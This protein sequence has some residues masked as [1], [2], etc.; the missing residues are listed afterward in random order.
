MGRVEV[1]ISDY[2]GDTKSALDN[3]VRV[4]QAIADLAADAGWLDTAL[5]TMHLI[6]GLMQVLFSLPLHA[7]CLHPCSCSRRQHLSLVGRTWSASEARDV[8]VRPS[9][10][11]AT[12]CNFFLSCLV[13]LSKVASIVPHVPCVQCWQAFGIFA[14]SSMAPS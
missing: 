2:V 5:A 9:G 10:L 12:F 3:S 6:Q 7:R 11:S 13:V 14:S 4:L 8:H 1:P